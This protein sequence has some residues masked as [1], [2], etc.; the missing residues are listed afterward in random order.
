MRGKRL[1]KRG[2]EGGKARGKGEG[3]SEQEEKK[4]ESKTERKPDREQVKANFKTIE[5]DV[6]IAYSNWRS[7]PPGSGSYGPPWAIS[8]RFIP[9][10]IFHASLKAISA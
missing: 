10:L 9:L 5:N 8:V 2:K 4:G 3:G 1:K 6:I 7:R